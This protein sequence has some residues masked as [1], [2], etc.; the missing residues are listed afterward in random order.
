MPTAALTSAQ[1]ASPWAISS[2]L[3]SAGVR[4]RSVDRRRSVESSPPPPPQPAS[5]SAASGQASDQEVS[6]EVS[7]SGRR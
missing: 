7:R 6:G 5:A 1:I 4:L 3:L 2:S